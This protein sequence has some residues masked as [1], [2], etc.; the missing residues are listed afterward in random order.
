M[1]KPPLYSRSRPASHDAQGVAQAGSPPPAVPWRVRWGR[2]TSATRLP[3][4][5]FACALVAIGVALYAAYR[6]L[7]RTLTQKDIDAAV[8]HT[9]DTTPL[10]SMA[11]KAYAAVRPSVVHVRGLRHVKADDAPADK[12]LKGRAR[13]PAKRGDPPQAAKGGEH[14]RAEADSPEELYRIGVGTGV[15]I[16]ATGLILTN[17]HVIDGAEAIVVTFADGTESPADVV[18]AQPENDLAVLKARIV[19][20]DLPPA[21]LRSTADLNVGDQVVAIGYPF[22]IGP[23]ASAGVVSGLRREY[24]S[25][26]GNKTLTNLIQFD[27][28]ANPGNSGGPLVTADGEVVGIV[29]GIFNPTDQRVFIGIG[30]AV[31]IENAAAAVGLSPF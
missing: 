27:A 12:S 17:L 25:P 24:H 14:P 15:V 16:V 7:P 19:P 26:E 2:R 29:T 10:P 1:R 18:S 28:A 20:D 30:F 11:A 3:I 9:L 13:P 22:G 4:A 31:P 23:S 6:P 21:T 5:L 8:L